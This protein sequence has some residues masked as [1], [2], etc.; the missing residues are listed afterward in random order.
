MTSSREWL[1]RL[2]GSLHVR[3][4]DNELD[5]ELRFHLDS[6]IR[7]A[8]RRSEGQEDAVRVSVQ[9]RER[10]QRLEN[11]QVPLKRSALSGAL[12][13]IR[14]ENTTASIRKSNRARI[15]ESWRLISDIESMTRPPSIRVFG[16]EVGRMRV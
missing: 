15:D 13:D 14:M 9:R 5:E 1:I 4:S 16:S 2:W 11:H 3:R 8:R 7:D 10:L 6:A 12:L